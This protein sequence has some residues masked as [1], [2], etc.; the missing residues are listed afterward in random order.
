MM[1]M[2]VGDADRKVRR[3]TKGPNEV[4]EQ[5]VARGEKLCLHFSLTATLVREMHHLSVLRSEG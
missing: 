4:S 2:V 3:R 5:S 1:M